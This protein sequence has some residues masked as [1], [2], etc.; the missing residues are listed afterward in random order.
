MPYTKEALQNMY[1][2]SPEDVKAALEICELSTDQEEYSDEEITAVDFQQAV[3]LVKQQHSQASAT[4]E[5]DVTETKKRR[6][7]KPLDITELL[8]KARNKGFKLT[9]M[10]A[11]QVLQACGLEEKDEYSSAECDRFLEAGD[12]IKNQGKSV[13]EVAQHFGLTTDTNASPSNLDADTDTL[14][15]QLGETT[16]LLGQEERELI[17]E[18]VKQKAKGDMAGLPKLYLQSLLEEMRSPEFQNEWQQLRNAFKDKIM[19]KKPTSP[20][21]PQPQP[22]MSLPPTSDNGLVSE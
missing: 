5:N 12:L 21:F 2:L 3:E 1:S 10:E 17:R 9:L 8:G 15:E 19:G 7:A 14:L 6:K 11:M 18:M 16:A 20:I 4:P 22:L 13:Q